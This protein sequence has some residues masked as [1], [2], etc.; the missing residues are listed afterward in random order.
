MKQNAD[1][2]LLKNLQVLEERIIVE[3]ADGK[4]GEVSLNSIPAPKTIVGVNQQSLSE[5]GGRRAEFELENGEVVEY[6]WDFFRRLI[7]PEFEKMEDNEN[8]EARKKLGE[9]ICKLRNQK[10][11]SQEQLAERSGLDRT[12]ISR[13]ERGKHQAGFDTLHSIAAGLQLPIQ[14][15]VTIDADTSEDAA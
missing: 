5:S 13:I 7:D 4:K 2:F 1:L 8:R 3:F 15:I 14:E 6:P 10:S 9:R 12:T 11:L